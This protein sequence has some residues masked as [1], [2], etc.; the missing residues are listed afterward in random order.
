[1]LSLAQGMVPY[2]RLHFLVAGLSPIVPKLNNNKVQK[3]SSSI[4]KDDISTLTRQCV[5]EQN[6]LQDIKDY[7]WKEDKYMAMQF[8]YRGNGIC[9]YMKE[10]NDKI[11]Y[12][13]DNGYKYIQWC[14]NEP[15]VRFIDAEIVSLPSDDVYVGDKQAVM[16]GNNTSIIRPMN[17]RTV[18]LYDILYSQRSWVHWWVG[19]VM[20]IC[21]IP[22]VSIFFISHY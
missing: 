21:F 12:L 20:V 2:P 15:S 11:R 18:K 5:M 7:E 10:A 9:Q 16:L 3:E 13:S 1:M 22:S 6:W 19:E 8:M 4:I 14:N 17:S